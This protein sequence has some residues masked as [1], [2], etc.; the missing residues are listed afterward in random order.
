M[1]SL[2]PGSVNK[3]QEKKARE[4]LLQEQERAALELRAKQ[5]RQGS[6][7]SEEINSIRTSNPNIEKGEATGEGGCI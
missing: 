2:L 5:L 1:I 6:E 7:G 3:A 4:R